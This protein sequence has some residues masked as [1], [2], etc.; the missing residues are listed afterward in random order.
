MPQDEHVA[1]DRFELIECVLQLGERLAPPAAWLAEVA[2]AISTATCSELAPSWSSWPNRT[3]RPAVR[4]CAPRC[5]R[6]TSII[7]CKVTERIQTKA[8]IPGLAW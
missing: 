2:S 3:S 6:C 1:I 5:R 7:L 4:S 8:G